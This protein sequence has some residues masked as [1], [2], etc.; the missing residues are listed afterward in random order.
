MKHIPQAAR[1]DVY[2]CDHCCH[3]HL[4]FIDVNGNAICDAAM[5]RESLAE[6][7]LTYPVVP[8]GSKEEIN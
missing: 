6:L 1:F 4:R 8:A 3:P 7:A 5:M 2:F